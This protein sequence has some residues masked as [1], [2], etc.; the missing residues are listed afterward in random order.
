M[1][2]MDKFQRCRGEGDR[3]LCRCKVYQKQ[4]AKAGGGTGMENHRVVQG[5]LWGANLCLDSEV[6][7]PNWG[8]I[9]CP[10]C[11]P[12]LRAAHAACSANLEI[13]R[14]ASGTPLMVWAIEPLT[15]VEGWEAAP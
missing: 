10:Q 1:N 11:G 5:L 7:T 2:L 4:V 12:P 9:S 3:L 15:F 6:K 8:M 14:L 13:D